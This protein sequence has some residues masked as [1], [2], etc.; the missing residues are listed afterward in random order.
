MKKTDEQLRRE[1]IEIIEFHL[2]Q[3]LEQLKN[4]EDSH[5]RSEARNEINIAFEWLAELP[6]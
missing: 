5:A 6:L 3:A 4:V 2:N 1:K